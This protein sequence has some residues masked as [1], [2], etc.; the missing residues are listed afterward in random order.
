MSDLLDQS[1]NLERA[2]H[3]VEAAIKAGADSADAVAARAVSSSVGL[4]DGAPEENEHS[5]NDS[6]A[7]RV[8]IDGCKAS[9]STNTTSDPEILAKLA[10]RAVAMARL[11]PRD[12]FARLA[13]RSDLME[14]DIVIDR[15]AAIDPYD[16]SIPTTEELLKMAYE[17]EEGALQVDGVTKSGGATA[18]HFLG[19][20]VLATSHGFV[21]AYLTSRISFSATAIAGLGMNMERDYSFSAAV[22]REDLKDPAYV[23]RRAG[24]RATGR[25]NPAKMETGTY[26]V[27][28][29]PRV[30]NSLIGHLASAING[31]AIARHTSFLMDRLGR[32]IFP[33]GISITDDPTLV[34]GLGSRPF[35]GEGVDCKPLAL[36]ED[37]YLNQWVL[38]SATAAEL[39]LKTNGR[40]TRSGANPY[41]STTNLTLTPGS[42][43]KEDLIR[44]VKDGVFIT[45]LIGHG[46]NGVTGDYSRGAA[47]FRIRNGELAESI[48]EITIAGNLSDMFARIIPADDLNFEQAVNAP[49]ILIEGMT[50]A[51]R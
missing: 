10:E 15:V 42:Q 44:G 8:F 28:F 12:P 40:A 5:E 45:D 49:S 26:D 19:G 21:G 46:V 27:I 4:R 50:V 33:K 30:A 1:V 41:P 2:Q 16:P 43:T 13:A 18:G 11:S 23:G 31:T 9:I 3:L 51:G 17:A 34:R 7:L 24:E 36:V 39:G 35:D 29:E 32:Q 20:A 25:V 47:G 22:H 6:L 48:S 38:D 37:G 14:N